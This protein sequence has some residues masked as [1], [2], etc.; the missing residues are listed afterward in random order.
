MATGDVVTTEKSRSLPSL[1]TI[2]ESILVGIALGF[3]GT[4]AL[5][6]A[7]AELAGIGTLPAWIRKLQRGER[8]L[9]LDNGNYFALREPGKMNRV[10]LYSMDPERRIV[11]LVQRRFN[12]ASR[13]GDWDL[14]QTFADYKAGEPVS[15]LNSAGGYESH[16][17]KS[18]D[19]AKGEV[20]LTPY[21]A[22]SRSEARSIL[23]RHQS[24]VTRFDSLSWGTGL[25]VAVALA[26]GGRSYVGGEKI[27]AVLDQV[28]GNFLV[29]GLLLFA[30][31]VVSPF[32]RA[33]LLDLRR[34]PRLSRPIDPGILRRSEARISQV[35]QALD[36]EIA[37]LGFDKA[38]VVF[39][40]AEDNLDI[41]EDEVVKQITGILTRGN[42][43]DLTITGLRE[44]QKP[45]DATPHIIGVDEIPLTAER[46]ITFA[47]RSEARSSFSDK[48][49]KL[50]HD[51]G[52]AS[53]AIDLIF[54]NFYDAVIADILILRH[55]FRSMRH[56]ASKH[57]TRDGVHRSEARMTR[58]DAV[59]MLD[60]REKI[61]NSLHDRNVR[62]P[63]AKLASI[64]RLNMSNALEGQI[65]N[66]SVQPGVLT[67]LDRTTKELKV[68]TL[69]AGNLTL[70]IEFKGVLDYGLVVLSNGSVR[71]LVVT[72]KQEALPAAVYYSINQGSVSKM[73]L[74]NQWAL[75]VRSLGFAEQSAAQSVRKIPAWFMEFTEPASG[76]NQGPQV[77]LGFM[78]AD[79]REPQI[80]LFAETGEPVVRSETRTQVDRKQMMDESELQRTIAKGNRILAALQL[81]DTFFRSL[82]Q[83]GETP[84]DFQ[85]FVEDFIV[86]KNVSSESQAKRWKDFYDKDELKSIRFGTR[87][88]E[89]QRAILITLRPFFIFAYLLYSHKWLTNHLP[90]ANAV[91]EAFVYFHPRGYTDEQIAETLMDFLAKKNHDLI[92]DT[93]KPIAPDLIRK[94]LSYYAF[95]KVLVS[96]PLREKLANG[97]AI[98]VRLSED[99]RAALRVLTRNDFLAKYPQLAETIGEAPA[100][101]TDGTIAAP[102]EYGKSLRLGTQIQNVFQ[103]TFLSVR[104]DKGRLIISGT[105]VELKLEATGS[106]VITDLNSS[107]GVEWGKSPVIG[108][109]TE[110][111]DK[112]EVLEETSKEPALPL[113]KPE[114]TAIIEG[115]K[116]RL[117]QHLPHEIISATEPQGPASLA[118]LL[119][120]KE[121][122]LNS[123]GKPLERSEARAATA[124]WSDF[125]QPN[126]PYKKKSF[127]DFLKDVP[128]PG[129]IKTTKEIMRGIYAAGVIAAAKAQAQLLRLVMPS[130]RAGEFSEALTA[131]IRKT[132]RMLLGVGQKTILTASDVLVL[133]SALV[134][135]NLE[136][137]AAMREAYSQ[138]TILASVRTPAERAF[139]EALNL[140]LVKAGLLPVLPVD[141]QDGAGFEE[142]LKAVSKAHGPVRV[143]AMFFGAELV[144]ELLRQQAFIRVNVTPRMLKGF[145]NAMGSLV[146]KLVSDLA[147]AFATAHSA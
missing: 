83:R 102:L 18:I 49:E 128:L 127:L 54:R 123:R 3:M 116:A 146:E 111:G 26:A 77:V 125:V 139:L 4:A 55:A 107:N 147:G 68:G 63:E 106:L 29:G 131:K 64:F 1:T 136:V 129:M 112:L 89:D 74:N 117:L 13:P 126:D 92:L 122:Q 79:F 66:N 15:F 47:S 39:R 75:P 61:L 31:M 5:I 58:T 69:S 142:H 33:P 21:L 51:I 145:L 118:S 81:Q 99:N 44:H 7:I 59:I 38:K 28:A 140:R 109:T 76:K 105:H 35:Q 65:T 53:F 86:N 100:A 8:V 132:A 70:N 12:L 104:D 143:T 110:S 10:S 120:A 137:A 91:E 6:G 41:P 97:A 71:V 98:S 27:T 43:F 62:K 48:L 95:E 114:A 130:N 23:R 85:A 124:F 119:A 90:K 2:S 24:L 96:T 101:V 93:S 73:K 45:W 34:T 121:M 67:V 17:I 22:E 42:A 72:Q 144:P 16:R 60:S 36:R 115:T 88:P 141:E 46:Q 11:T 80:R 84:G 19:F 94:L 37:R 135:Q 14:F 82:I 133:S 108:T 113:Q 25:V 9:T 20:V 40:N 103:K 87:S 78:P 138:A 30:A 50:D 134:S 52:N 57:P 32:I 56:Q